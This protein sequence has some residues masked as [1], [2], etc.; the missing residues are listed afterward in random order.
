MSLGFLAGAVNG[1]SQ[2][3]G[4]TITVSVSPASAPEWAV[5]WIASRT[6][7][8]ASCTATYDGAAMTEIGSG[9]DA[10]TRLFLLTTPSSASP[11]NCVFTYPSANRR[12]VCGVQVGTGPIN[13]DDLAN[14]DFTGGTGTSDTVSTPS[15]DVSGILLEFVWHLA[16]EV[17]T[18]GSSQTEDG[19]QQVVS[20][21]P[22][23]GA[24]AHKTPASGTNALQYSWATSIT[25]GHWMIQ[26][27]PTSPG[28]ALWFF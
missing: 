14:F 2:L 25:Y 5:G 9:T 8:L 19:D 6:S 3:P 23:S 11:A 7:D 24:I 27:T 10:N 15:G 22:I 17:S 1:E 20:A 21:N 16:E 4:T 12:I 18:P 26:L 28:G 13:L